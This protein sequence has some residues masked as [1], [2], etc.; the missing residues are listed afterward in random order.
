M[1]KS[2]ELTV[3]LVGLVAAVLSQSVEQNL[4]NGP[5]QSDTI[6]INACPQCLTVLDRHVG[7]QLKLEAVKQQI[8]SKLNLHQRP[9]MTSPVTRE[10]VLEALR[11][12]SGHL[13]PE[14]LPQDQP[15][16]E[17]TE[18]QEQD[19]DDHEEFYGKTSE[20]IVFSEHGGRWNENILLDFY[21]PQSRSQRLRVVSANLWIQLRQKTPRV[22][23]E[24]TPRNNLTLYVFQADRFPNNTVKTLRWLRSHDVES[25][26]VGWQRFNLR[27]PVRDW[28]SKPESTKLTLLVD[29][30]GC[31][32]AVEPV[33]FSGVNGI[34]RRGHRRRHRHSHRHNQSSA[35]GI[36]PFLAISTEPIPRR[37]SRRYA[38]TCNTHTTQCCKQ[39]LWVSFKQLNWDDWIVWPRGYSANYCVGECGRSPQTPDLFPDR[40]YYSQV[41]DEYRRKN[42]FASITPCCA[43]TKLTKMSIVYL[44]GDRNIYK[45]DL[46]NMKVEECGCT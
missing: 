34:R 39:S 35:P 1:S 30:S 8:L 3:A 41:L 29:C 6:L 13:F 40:Y 38:V 26:T 36:R 22:S 46:P 15:A 37:R 43:P 25:S 21:H 14:A 12:S 20:I 24:T 18:D 5:G 42:P 27:V 4:D 7:K 16:G 33:L 2:E 45:A 17:T 11:R 10:V 31:G 44:D 23:D 28:F 9:N 19:E 32:T